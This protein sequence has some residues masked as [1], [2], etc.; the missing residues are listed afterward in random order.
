[1]SDPLARGLVA[2]GVTLVLVTL[3]ATLP[4]FPAPAPTTDYERAR[5]MLE[6]TQDWALEADECRA[7]LAGEDPPSRTAGC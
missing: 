1:M 3:V 5:F 7:I 6:C 2:F 4:P